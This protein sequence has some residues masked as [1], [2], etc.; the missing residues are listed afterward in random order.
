MNAQR[1]VA[2]NSR[3]AMAQARAAFGE[4]AV[5]LSSRSTE[6]GFEVVATSED[7]L[8]HI[9]AQ[10]ASPAA[11]QSRSQLPE[12]PVGRSGRATLGLQQR[13]A[14]QLPPVSP[15]ST[16]AQDTETLAMSTLSFQEYVR[17]RMLRKRR[18]TLQGKPI[19]T[20]PR[21]PAQTA[22]RPAAP[23]RPQPPAGDGI[24][25][26]FGA[27]AA[28]AAA[29]QAPRDAGA[30][31]AADGHAAAQAAQLAAQLDSLKA[32]ME[33]RFQTLAWLG[34]SRQNPIQAQLMHKF[35]RAGYSP[36]VARAVLERLP[37][38][39]AA[40]EAWRWTLE[41]LAHNLR[42]AREPG[43]LCDEGGVFALIGPTGVGKTT[44]AAKLAAQCVKAYGANSVG[45]ITLDTYRVAG[46]EQLRAY[47]RML[48]VVA[49]LAHD[50]AALQ[51]L[52]E[53]LANKR[54]VIIDTAGLGQ[55]DPRI[56]EMMELL[57]A[58]QIKKLLVVNAGAHGDTLDD[59]FQAYKDTGLHGTILSK[60]DEAAK[61]GPAVDA[62]I[63]H[64]V[65][66]RGLTT[67]Q[68][69]PEDWQRPDAAALVRMSM[70]GRGKSAFDPTTAE[71]PFF[72]A[73]PAQ[74]GWQPEGAAHA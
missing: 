26:P 65:V 57:Q 35:I 70:G 32:M 19:E 14:Q 38:Q 63:R 45:L 25:L 43:Q 39:H 51:D 66:L 68:R 27:A 59:V 64:Q 48:G 47:G 58:P 4:Q 16:V 31:A 18:E 7:Q 40:S 11:Q 17:E 12:T 56:P 10:A 20:P 44:T 24:V 15:D 71:L 2:P 52:L 34:Q 28:P 21:P 72:F 62:L 3:D 9:A 42:V 22:K 8:S 49:H 36:T 13:A 37:A 53:L 41:V 74:T 29:R 33:E 67:G 54:M 1:F 73:D 69:V 46:Y 5:I 55:K 50:R 60:V 23:A 30:P 61:L 6:H